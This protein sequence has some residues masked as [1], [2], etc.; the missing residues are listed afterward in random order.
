MHLHTRIEILMIC[1]LSS[2]SVPDVSVNS[3]IRHCQQLLFFLCLC[4]AWVFFVVVVLSCFG[5]GF[6]FLFFY[7]CC[8]MKILSQCLFHLDF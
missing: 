6:V 3:L 4:T 7:F 5:Y 8:P 1:P 2:V